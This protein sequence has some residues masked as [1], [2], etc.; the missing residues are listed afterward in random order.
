MDVCVFQVV[1]LAD[2]TNQG[3]L[4]ITVVL[5]ILSRHALNA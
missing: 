1:I 5:V 3:G 2:R 4:N